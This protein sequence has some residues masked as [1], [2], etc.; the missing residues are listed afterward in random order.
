VSYAAACLVHAL[1][2]PAAPG[3]LP[4]LAA[5][6]TGC[7]P[8]LAR[9]LADGACPAAVVAA[10]SGGLAAL[11]RL[12]ANRPVVLQARTGLAAHAPGLRG[13]RRG[14]GARSA[15]MRLKASSVAVSHMLV[16]RALR[17]EATGRAA[18]RWRH[19]YAPSRLP[20]RRRLLSGGARQALTELLAPGGSAH[21]RQ[22]AAALLWRLACPPAGADAGV[23]ADVCQRPDL[24]AG[25]AHA[26]ATG[27]PA[28]A[29]VWQALLHDPGR[30]A[31]I[32]HQLAL[33]VLCHVGR[34]AKALCVYMLA[35]ALGGCTLCC[36]CRGAVCSA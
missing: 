13:R 26:L 12:P 5:A 1:A 25:L 18:L 33:P 16:K 28:A 30:C 10:A 15:R 34:L 29:G 4:H 31:R 35:V 22:R 20:A 23:H 7:A 17:G 19:P 32:P 6:G 21:G 2:A 24:L 14:S 9:R 8:S 27:T 11:A 3:Q 36:P